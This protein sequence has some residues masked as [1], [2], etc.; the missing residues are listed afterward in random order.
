MQKATGA[1]C[2][3]TRVSGSRGRLHDQLEQLAVPLPCA[4]RPHP[5][6]RSTPSSSNGSTTPSV[7]ATQW[8]PRTS[9]PADGRCRTGPDRLGQR[10]PPRREP[11]HEQ[12]ADDREPAGQSHG[13]PAQQRH[14]G[15]RAGQRARASSAGTGHASRT[16]ETARTAAVAG[17]TRGS[18]VGRRRRAARAAAAPP[19][20]RRCRRTGPAPPA[21]PGRPSTSCISS[22]AWS[23]RLAVAAEPPRARRRRGRRSLSA[24][25]GSAPCARSSARGRVAQLVAQ[26]RRG[27][28]PAGGPEPLHDRRA[29]ALRARPR[30]L[31][32]SRLTRTLFYGL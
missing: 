6:R 28:R 25:A 4:R 11:V 12:R 23:S 7:S 5:R 14:D 30:V 26:R 1:G 9:S 20:G 13:L 17:S 18:V 15:S 27:D 31:L 21:G 2:S 8:S 24:R 22:A 32:S 19:R 3:S 29:R 16:A 10:V